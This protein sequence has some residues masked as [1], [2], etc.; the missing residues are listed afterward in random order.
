MVKFLSLLACLFGL[1]LAGAEP[2][3]RIADTIGDAAVREAA[4][5]RAQGGNAGTCRQERVTLERALAGLRAGEYDLVLAYR[6]ALPED[7]RGRARD[8]AIEAAMIAVNAANV[9][10]SFSAKD[11]AEIFS[12]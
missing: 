1:T 9:R 6:S 11:L 7:L 8:Y 4:I 2:G 12:G 10:S 5:R 3:L